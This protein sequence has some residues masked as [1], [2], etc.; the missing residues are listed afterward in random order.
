[1]ALLNF[2]LKPFTQC[3]FPLYSQDIPDS[4]SVCWFWLT[5]SDYYL[6][7]GNI[8]LYESSDEWKEKYPLPPSP[9]LDYHFVRF[10]E[11]FF[12]L[13]PNLSQPMPEKWFSKMNTH[14]KQKELHE[15]VIDL[16]QTEKPEEYD[17]Y[18]Q[19][20]CDY[21]NMG[22]LD[23]G[24]LATPPL[25]RFTH[26]QDQIHIYWDCSRKND[27]GSTTW[28]GGIGQHRILYSDFLLEIEDLLH[29]FFIAMDK[30]L[31]DLKNYL[32]ATPQQTEYILYDLCQEQDQQ[33][34]LCKNGFDYLLEEHQQRKEFFYSILSKVK[35]N[36]YP[37]FQWD[38][39]E[40]AWKILEMDNKK[41]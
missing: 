2:E 16:C 37:P 10:L 3:A 39:L 27:D 15:K 31:N 30:Q 23:S 4:K 36:E 6:T 9:F 28:A 26:F 11:D 24:F 33:K 40:V 35:N 7:V 29:R 13:L 32:E 19:L 20:V 18:D 8:N 1:M 5:D 22:D 17:D 25:I 12:D 34:G 14:K 38:Q 21:Y 41:G